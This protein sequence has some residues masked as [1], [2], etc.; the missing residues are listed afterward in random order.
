MLS[1]DEYVRELGATCPK[2]HSQNLG[3][4]GQ[5][6]TNGSLF[7]HRTVDCFNCD[8]Q[9]AEQYKLIGYIPDE[10][11]DRQAKSNSDIG[12]TCCDNCDALVHTE[13]LVS[14]N[15]IYERVDPGEPMPSGECPDC[16]G[17]C[18]A[19]EDGD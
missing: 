2:C 3:D 13:E 15:D 8:A 7:A 5:L 18:H 19:V 4:V 1:D 14:I 16:G 10:L 6:Q 12:M 11:S 9:W 17:L